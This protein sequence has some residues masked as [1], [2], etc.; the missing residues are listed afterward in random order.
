[1]T[2]SSHRG[3][4]RRVNRAPQPQLGRINALCARRSSDLTAGV[5]HISRWL[6]RRFRRGDSADSVTGSA[7]DQQYTGQFRGA[8]H[9][10]GNR[11]G[12]FDN[13]TFNDDAFNGVDFGRSHSRDERKFHLRVRRYAV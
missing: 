6:Q 1:M 10:T 8:G 5:F 4:V 3:T 7:A 2:E 12:T 11:L 13:N 9:G